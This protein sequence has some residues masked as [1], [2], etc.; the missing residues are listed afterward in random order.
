M[1]ICNYNA[2][3]HTTNIYSLSQFDSNSK[4]GCIIS[5]SKHLYRLTSRKNG[6]V[7]LIMLKLPKVQNV[8]D[9]EIQSQCSIYY[10]SF[11]YIAFIYRIRKENEYIF[12][13]VSTKYR[14]QELYLAEISLSV[15]LN[16]VP[17]KILNVRVR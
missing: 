3:P 7:E 17:Y 13:L 6:E 9:I 12:V 11:L 1:L 8:S 5:T 14:N 15:E 4:Q 16:Y 10:K 2:L